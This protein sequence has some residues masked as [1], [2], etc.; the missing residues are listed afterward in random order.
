MSYDLNNYPE[1]FESLE[2]PFT[3]RRIV[4]PN[5]ADLMDRP[6]YAFEK[7]FGQI[8][9]VIELFDE[10]ESYVPTVQRVA[11]LSKPRSGS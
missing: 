9:R 1:A 2:R 3:V 10:S 5:G 4:P 11:Q 8:D 6:A 7:G